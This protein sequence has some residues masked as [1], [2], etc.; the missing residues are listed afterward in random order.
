M[1]PRTGWTMAGPRRCARGTMVAPANAPRMAPAP[2][3]RLILVNQASPARMADAGHA[4][5]GTTGR[6]IV[7]PHRPTPAV[8]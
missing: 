7:A 8:Q 3:A 6:S 4:T 2:A 5:I 1:G